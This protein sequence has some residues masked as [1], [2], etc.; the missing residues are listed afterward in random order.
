MAHEN[1]SFSIIP[2]SQQRFLNL[3]GKPRH[4]ERAVPLPRTESCSD[5]Q[6]EEGKVNSFLHFS[7]KVPENV[8]NVSGSASITESKADFDANRAS[9]LRRFR[10]HKNPE[11]YLR[12][13][14]RARV[15]LYH[16]YYQICNTRNSNFWKTKAF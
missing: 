15:A 10:L 6:E 4:R 1:N 13:S 8:R 12:H 11:R 9:S 3:Q 14:T 5:L 7:F 16:P 2:D